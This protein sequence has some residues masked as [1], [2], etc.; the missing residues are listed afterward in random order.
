MRFLFYDRVTTLEKGRRIV[1]VKSLSSSEPFLEKHFTKVA[2]IP[3][4][5]LIEAMAQLLGWLVAYSHDFRLVAIMTLIGEARLPAAL[6]PGV[7]LDVEGH[8]LTNTE[9][10]S[11]G[12]ATVSLDGNVIAQ[13]DR[14]I[15]RHFP[16]PEPEPL[17]RRFLY[18]SG[19]EDL[20]VF[21]HQ[22]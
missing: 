14:L 6:K 16:A 10:D 7:K 21:E 8:L 15:F 19:I 3:S 1:G 22:Q 11:L 13:V 2:L 17:V 18:Y 5:L 4:T 20:A 9:R 12:S